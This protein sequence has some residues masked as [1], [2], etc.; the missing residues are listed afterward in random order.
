VGQHDRFGSVELGTRVAAALPDAR[1]ETL[2]AGHIPFFDDPARCAGLIHDLAAR[3]A[4][5]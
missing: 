1:L 3:A 5:G 2:D 4:S